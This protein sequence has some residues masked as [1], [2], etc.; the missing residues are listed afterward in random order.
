[1]K[2]RVLQETRSTAKADGV[3]DEENE[4]WVECL[5]IVRPADQ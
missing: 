3:H 1:M 2:R 4:S 5:G